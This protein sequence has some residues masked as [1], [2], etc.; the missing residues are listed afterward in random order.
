MKR[1]TLILLINLANLFAIAYEYDTLNRLKIA[2]YENGIS[3]N[4]SYD[5]AGNVLSVN[6]K[7][8]NLLD[9]DGD[10]TPDSLDTDDDNDGITDVDEKKYGLDPLDP[11]DAL[12]DSDGDGVSNLDEII[13]GTDP[14]VADSSS[15]SAYLFNP[16]LIMIIDKVNFEGDGDGD[17]HANNDD[18]FPQDPSEWLDTDGDNTGDNADTDDDGDGISDVDEKKYGLNPLNPE[19][20]ALDSDDDGVSNLDEINA[21]T[22]PTVKDSN[23]GHTRPFILSPVL[24]IDMVLKKKE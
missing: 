23:T 18:A 5:D 1:L 14:T 6:S 17:G 16:M 21:G 9:S 10:G 8:I 7:G 4:Y 11:K 15:R 19:D 13:A 3:M 24:I 2:T 22:D 20:A 12:L